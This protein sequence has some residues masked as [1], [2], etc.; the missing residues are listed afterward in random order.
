ME[1]HDR[2]VHTYSSKTGAWSHKK[3]DWGYYRIAPKSPNA[4]VNVMLHLILYDGNI[5]LVSVDVEGKIQKIILPPFQAGKFWPLS[6]YVGQSQG[7]SH[8]IYHEEETF[9]LRC[10]Q[11]RSDE[12][13][14][15]VLEDY[16]TQQWVLKDTVSFLR[17][18]GKRCCQ[19]FKDYD[20]VAIHPDHNLVY[21]VHHCNSKL[22]SYDMDSKEVSHLC[23]LD[24]AIGAA[25]HS[26]CSLLLG[27]VST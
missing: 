11:G 27:V 24:M 25:H 18:F 7:R 23:T 1:G 17:L 6:D 13:L 15:W 9:D 21:L 3:C 14:I 5:R 4:Y 10:E 2:S 22:I 12:L 8:Y 20:V 26:V 19:I 16:D